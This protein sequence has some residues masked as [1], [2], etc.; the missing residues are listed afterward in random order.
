MKNRIILPLLAMLA[1]V[2]I[3]LSLTAAPAQAAT[4]YKTYS[5]TVAGKPC[6]KITATRSIFSP[7]KTAITASATKT[8]KEIVDNNYDVNWTFHDFSSTTGLQQRW[9]NPTTWGGSVGNN[10]PA[11]VE[12][13]RVTFHGKN[14]AAKSGYRA[15]VILRVGY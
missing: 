2:G 3:A 15:Y 1:T 12:Y 5:A 6:L 13:I 14:T 9:V 11:T 8:C 10:L 7:G 4:I